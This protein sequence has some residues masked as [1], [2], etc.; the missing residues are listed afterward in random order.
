LIVKIRSLSSLAGALFALAAAAVLTSC[1]GGGA[2]GNPETAGGVSI[3]PSTGTIYAGV[4]FTFQISGAR[5]PY[6]LSSSEPGVLSV[7]SQITSHSLEVVAANPA[8]VDVGLQPGDL[9]VRTVIITVRAGDG[10]TTSATMKVG[11]NF[12]TGYGVTF[13]PITCPIALSGSASVQV[14]AGG[15]TAIQFQAAFNGNLFGNRLFKLDVVRGPFKF[16]FPQGGTDVSV[17][18]QSDHSGEVHAIIQATAGVPTQLAV[19][20][21]TDVGSGASTDFV[22]TITGTANGGK[23]TV[24]P[25]SITF[26]GNLTTD[27]GTGSSSFFVFDGSP[28]FLALSSDPGITVTPQSSSNPGVFTVTSNS[29][30]PPCRTGTVVVTDSQGAR[31]TV[32]VKSLPGANTPPTPPDFAVAPT[33]ITLVCAGSGSVTAVGGSGS[34]SATSSSSLVTAVVSGSTVT[35]TRAGPAGPGSGTLASKVAVTDGST[36][37]TVDVTSPA[38]CP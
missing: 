35:I 22:F 34:Y 9:P 32:D 27:C 31:A 28:P 30:T 23:L 16:V 10:Q 33:D 17:T 38:T 11:Q 1:G 20:R 7:P 4:P 14:C 6:S 3:S 15:E 36:I 5:L 29:N 13:N 37:Q 18:V 2:Q 21:V 25:S 8:V 26:T 19:L 24:I 12:L